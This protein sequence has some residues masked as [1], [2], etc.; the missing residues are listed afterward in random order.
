MARTAAT[1]PGNAARVLRIVHEGGPVSRAELTRRTGLNR[2]TVLALV[3]ELVERGLVHEEFPTA[4]AEN[5]PAGV[6]RPSAVVRAS[7]DVVA[8]AVTVEIDA[9]GVALVALDGTVRDRLVEPQATVPSAG[10]AV[11]AV[12]RVLDTLTRRTADAVQ[13]VGVGVAVPGIVRVEDG[14]V[15]D[16][17]HLGWR[18]EPFAGPLAERLGLPVRA[19]NDANVGAWAERLYGSA[20]GVDDLVYLNGGAS[21]IGG[22]IVSAGRPFSGAD[23]YAGELG[24]TFVAANGI[25]CHC[26]AVGCLE[27]EASRGALT[28]VTGTPPDDLDALAD[29]LAAGRADVERVVDRQVTALATAI[30]NAIH[31]VDPEVVVLGGF[32]GVLLGHVGDRV[33]DDVRAQTMAAM[34][35]RLRIVPAALG[36]DVLVRG[37]AELGFAD[38][39][40]DGTLPAAV[41]PAA[42]PTAGTAA[43][44][45]AGPAAAGGP[46]APGVAATAPTTTTTDTVD[47]TADRDDAVEEARSA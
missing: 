45:A 7:H 36:R 23:G 46:A 24:H 35:D 16:A 40:R 30:R 15:R 29:A 42:G 22:G 33:E 37:A 18:D 10:A 47:T 14:V 21:G 17:P 9:V 12:A 28:A 27:T 2:S 31:T 44:P 6:G 32:L 3:G 11:D 5:R 25:R 41:G 34:T 1:T 4:G 20:R 39:L 19:A 13:V 8:A 26:G 43:G 38:L